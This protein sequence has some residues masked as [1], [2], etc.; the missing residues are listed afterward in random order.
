MST[1]RTDDPRDR[2]CVL[3]SRPSVLRG[4]SAL[5]EFGKVSQSSSV[6]QAPASMCHSC[7]YL[8]VPIQGVTAAIHSLT[9]H[10]CE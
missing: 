9:G 8:R 7:A 5:W 3:H 4:E 1:D 10:T 6:L 2:L